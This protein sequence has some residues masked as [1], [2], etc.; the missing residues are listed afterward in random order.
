MKKTQKGIEYYLSLPYAIGIQPSPEGGYGAHVV[1]L[2]GC[3]SQGMTLPEAVE[4]IEDA[5]RAWLESALEEGIPIPEPETATGYSGK[6]L[7]R[8]PKSLHE[9]LARQ[10]RKEGVSLNQLVLYYLARQ[11]GTPLGRGGTRN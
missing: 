2:P 1:E 7:V 8:M 11:A 6:L 3:I 5:K 10:A 4:M 9:S